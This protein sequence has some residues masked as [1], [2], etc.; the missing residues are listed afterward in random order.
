MS[1]DIFDFWAGVEGHV[2]VHPEDHPIL[3]RAAHNFDLRCLPANFDGPLR[4]A[5][6]VLLY[7]SPGQDERDVEAAE[8]PETQQRYFL[9]RKGNSPLRSDDSDRGW[10]WWKARTRRFGPWQDL[11]SKVAVLNISPYHSVDFSDYPMLAALPSCRVALNWAQTVLFPQAERGERVVICL[12]AAS[13]WGLGKCGR[14]DRW[15]FAPKVTRAGFMVSKGIET[16]SRDDVV[17]AAKEALS[18]PPFPG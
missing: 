3:E 11:K 18:L 7:L 16:A 15:L 12:R 5:R 2:R 1:A 9:M 8:R 14:Y 13:Y 17:E 10:N 6:V 4:T